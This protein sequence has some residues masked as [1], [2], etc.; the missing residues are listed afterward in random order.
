MASVNDLMGVGMEG[1]TAALLGNSPQ[2]LTC[3]GTTAGAAALIQTQNVVLTTAASNTGA[4][5]PSIAPLGTIWYITNPSSTTAV[6]YPP[7]SNTFNLSGGGASLSVAQYN[8]VIAIRL[9]STTWM[10]I[11]SA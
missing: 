4:I 8:S 3:T 6:L 1:R 9:T 10:T 11:V 5:L 7:T 2:A